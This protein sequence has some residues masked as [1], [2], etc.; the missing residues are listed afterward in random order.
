[1]SKKKIAKNNPQIKQK[2]ALLPDSPGVYLMTNSTEDVIYVGKSKNLKNRVRSYFSGTPV[3]TKTNDLV[4]KITD[5]DYIL[6]KTEE[7]ALILESNLIKKYKPKYNISLKDDKQYP[8]IKVTIKESFPKVFVTRQVTKDGS[9][10]F[11]PYTD[12][13]ALR[14]TIRL[15]EWIFPLRTCKK[16]ITDGEP[17]FKKSCINFQLGKCPAPCIGQISKE[18]YKRIVSNAVNFLSGRNKIVIEDLKKEMNERSTQ[19]KFEEAA[20]IRDKIMNIQK[21]NRSRNMFFTDDKNRDVIGIY[22]EDN[23]AA[24]SVLKILSGKLLNKEIYSL[25]NV[26]GSLLPELMKAFIEQYYSLRLDNLP[27]RIF[28]QIKPE[29]YE[30]LNQVL[31]KKLLIP[32]RGEK[33]SLIS[34]ARENAFNYVEEQKLK[35][36][37]KSNRTIFPIK[38]LKD[39]LNLKKLPRK[40]ICLDISTIQ[41]TDTVSSLVFFE[42][43]KPRKKNYR[44]F[45]IKS[46]KGQDDY[47]SLAETLERYLKKLEEQEKPDLIVIDG[48]KG[49]LNSAYR[50]LEKMKI[51]DI[52]MISLAKKLEEIFIPGRKDSIILPKSSSALRML[53]KLRDESHRFA[54]TFHRKRRSSRTLTSELDKIKG[55][56]FTTKFALLQE[57]GSIENI[58]K[59]TIK[60][61]TQIKGIGKDTASLILNNL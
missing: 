8:F 12:A 51:N 22:K 17:A 24:V 60:D 37:R 44:H 32:K 47:A 20:G 38:E 40:M 36:L 15:M 21:L 30:F 11:G 50:I 53:I 55:I 42:N 34:I 9:R 56:G 39:K 19:M 49:Q 33:Q 13:K 48:G 29:S 31:K 45:I 3:D 6:T 4:K 7:Q 57:F 23:K 41:G 2:L 46:V 26:E 59:A 28:L 16:N 1:M 35:Y 52:E 43:G 18:D 10:Y 54:I 58:K 61:L 27:Y 14:K 25:D 5:F